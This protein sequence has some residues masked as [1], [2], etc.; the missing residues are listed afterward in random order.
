MVF[1]VYI[2]SNNYYR[3]YVAALNGLFK[4]TDRELD[5]F[6]ELIRFQIER[7]ATIDLDI[8]D[9]RSRRVV[10][11]RANTRKSN[12]SKYVAVLKY[13]NILVQVDGNWVINPYLVPMS[14]KEEIK[15]IFE[16]K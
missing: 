7:S 12:F 4:L 1:R 8:L 13:K 3:K 2:N 16:I 5:V 15:F 14:E 9:M 6:S 11:K 10:M